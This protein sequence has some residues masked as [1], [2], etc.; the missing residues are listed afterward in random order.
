VNYAFQDAIT[1]AEEINYYRL[2]QVDLNGEY[3]FFGPISS[4]CD[5]EIELGIQIYP[6]PSKGSFMLEFTNRQD[7][8]LL[9]CVKD[10]MG[11]EVTTANVFI[12]AGVNLVP[13]TIAG[14]TTGIY[15]LTIETKDGS[16]VKKL[17]IE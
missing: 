17:T 5:S 16:L 15:F 8:Q 13:M 9:I 4:T 12:A 11:H 6:N 7:Q 2:K 3:Q 14:M 10:V 1:N